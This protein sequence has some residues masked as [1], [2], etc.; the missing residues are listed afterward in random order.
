MI[1]DRVRIGGGAGI[2][3]HVTIGTDS[4]PSATATCARGRR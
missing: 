1:G 4:L 3:D 2:A